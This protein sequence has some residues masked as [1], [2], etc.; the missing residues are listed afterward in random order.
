MCP[1]HA[2]GRDHQH[3]GC[4]AQGKGGADGGVAQLAATN[5]HT[6]TEQVCHEGLPVWA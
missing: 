4:Q 6:G 2:P 3:D 5:G 1:F